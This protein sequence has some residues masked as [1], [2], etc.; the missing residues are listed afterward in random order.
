MIC[1]RSAR[2]LING[3]PV[4]MS[5]AAMSMLALCCM[6]GCGSGGAAAGVS[7]TVTVNGEPLAEGAIQFLPDEG[8]DGKGAA[9]KIAAGSYSVPI[10]ET[11][12]AG[13][14]TVRI[15]AYRGTGVMIEGEPAIDPESETVDDAGGGEMSEETEQ[16]LPGEY[17]AASTLTA[18]LKAGD[19]TQDFALDFDESD[20]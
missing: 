13:K 10:G 20:E 12:M 18:D 5:C 15:M 3:S 11:L 2:K 17:N 14:H 4:W 1:K 9:A 19:N 6:V 7:G 16:Y 8:T